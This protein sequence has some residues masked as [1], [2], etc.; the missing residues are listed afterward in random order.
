MIRKLCP[1]CGGDAVDSHPAS[2]SPFIL[3]RCQITESST[4][5][6]FCRPCHFVFFERGLSTSEANALYQ[7]YRQDDYNKMRLRLEPS[8]SSYVP[9]FEN[10]FS[11]Y[12]VQRVNELLGILRQAELM[13]SRKLLDFG[14][15]GMIPFR[16]LPGAKIFVDDLSVTGSHQQSEG[17]KDFDLIFASEVLEHLT[18]PVGAIKDL[19]SR[20]SKTG[21][22]VIDVPMEYTGSIR[23][24]WDL[25]RIKGGSLVSMH[26]HINHFSIEAVD[27]LLK[28]G[29]FNPLSIV[30]TPLNFIVAV[31]TTGEEQ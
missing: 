2:I 24:A 12:W 28:F 27:R 17:Q 18:D 31:A 11:D 4:N 19:R 22:L 6:L 3:E 9:M 7:G 25:Q 14:G 23:Q 29:G 13:G 1:L 20:L 5:S 16:L 21:S 30:Q 15:D 8:Y 26:E 10:R